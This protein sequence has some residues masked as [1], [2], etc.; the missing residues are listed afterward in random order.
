MNNKLLFFFVLLCISS[1]FA[2]PLKDISATSVEIDE[3]ALNGNGDESLFVTVTRVDDLVDDD[4]SLLAERLMAV[5][6]T[7]DVVENQLMCNGQPIDIGISN[8]QVESQIASNPDKLTITSEEEAAILADSFDVGLVTVEVTVSL[9]D[10]LKTDDGMTFRRLAIKELITEVNE[11]NIVQT[12][13]V[14]QLL[15][16]FEDGSMM[17]WKPNASD[18]YLTSDENDYYMTDADWIYA[19]AGGFFLP[20]ICVALIFAFKRRQEATVY[21]VVQTEEA[22]EQPPA[23]IK[24]ELVVPEEK[25]PLV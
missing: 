5:Q 16:V 22:K 14:Q 1:I 7:F 21:E 6:V 23:Y 10:E 8:I 9:I 13:A 2:L 24:E 19:I 3:Q 18:Y 17:R 15:D 25:K 11:H 4:G 20:A 12:E